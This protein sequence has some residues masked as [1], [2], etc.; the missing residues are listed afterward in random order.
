MLE[1]KLVKNEFYD[2]SKGMF[3]DG[4]SITIEL[5]HSLYSL[6][7][8]ESKW[9]KPFLTEE[10][11][12][13]EE[14]LDYVKCMTLT[15]NVDSEWYNHLSVKQAQEISSYISAKSTA[16]WFSDTPTDKAVGPKR[17]IT[18][19]VIYYWMIALEIPMECQHW[20]LNRLITLVRVTNSH[21]QAQNKKKMKPNELAARNRDLNAQRRAALNTT[22]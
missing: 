6:S 12:T 14:A 19:E 21:H 9:E 3:V 8:W 15:S 1:I 20:H 7:K 11:H 18:A 5:E 13:D 22:G 17:T 16:T 4:E 10:P 2:D